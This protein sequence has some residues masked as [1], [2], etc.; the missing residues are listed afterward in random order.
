MQSIIIPRPPSPASKSGANP[1]ALYCEGLHTLGGHIDKP[2]CTATVQT[3]DLKQAPPVV[4]V[5]STLPMPT[6]PKSTRQ[7]LREAGKTAAAHT[8]YTRQHPLQQLLPQQWCN[9]FQ[10]G[11]RTHRHT[12][13]HV[14]LYADSKG[15]KKARSVVWCR[16]HFWRGT[17]GPTGNRCGAGPSSVR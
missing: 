10:N 4:D 12:H 11:A 14:M 6:L 5:V 16:I 7:P 15:R 13:T 2:H 8:R 1:T 3:R 9:L 17:K